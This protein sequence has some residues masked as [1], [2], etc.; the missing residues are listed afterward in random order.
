MTWLTKSSPA[1][2]T[3]SS[4]LRRLDLFKW[5]YWQVA[6]LKPIEIKTSRSCACIQPFKLKRCQKESQ[7]RP[8]CRNPAA[9]YHRGMSRKRNTSERD[10]A[11]AVAKVHIRNA[12]MGWRANNMFQQCKSSDSECEEPK[13]LHLVT[14]AASL[15]QKQ[16]FRSSFSSWQ[17][18][19]CSACRRV[20]F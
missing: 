10:K 14:V 9:R 16:I 4:V 11:S 20:F 6:W 19:S 12:S 2:I 15:L 8:L 17:I 5:K 18:S 1:S 7:Y 13:R 3:D